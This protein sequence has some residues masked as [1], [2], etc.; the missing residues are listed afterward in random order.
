MLRASPL[1]VL[2]PLTLLGAGLW[3]VGSEAIARVPRAVLRPPADFP[4]ET[5]AL[6]DLARPE[7]SGWV[8]ERPGSCAVVVLLHGRGASKADMVARAKL[9]FAFGY[10]VALFDLSGHGE[11]AGTMRGFGYAEAED[12]HR[13][14][15]FAKGRFD[16]Q[17]IGAVG[18]SLGAAALVFA[19]DKEPADAYVLEQL[20]ATLIETT[21]LR[22]PIPFARKLQAWL[23]L[24]QMPLRLG[25][26][27][28]DVRPIDHMGGI[29][30]PALLLA[31]A[32]DP[33]IDPSQ[34]HALKQAS[35]LRAELVWF[36]GAGHVDLQR[37]D[38]GK[39]RNAVVPFL[40]KNLCRNGVDPK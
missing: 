2:V 31:G 22:S 18:S 26:G 13:I 34:T 28:A 38:A 17:R 11:S 10:S 15:T 23:L 24:S 30:G 40:E 20:Y 3:S 29:G 36:E 14:L 37:Y 21:A 25:Y 9:L 8:A 12:V 1:A 19:A 16:G 33:F 39:Y 32:S 27:A 6:A 35:H 5:V 7:L 4:L